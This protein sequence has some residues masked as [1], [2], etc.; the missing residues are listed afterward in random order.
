MLTN[1]NFVVLLGP[2]SEAN[3]IGPAINVATLK[4]DREAMYTATIFVE[5][6]A[7]R[8][9]LQGSLVKNPQPTDW[10]NIKI[11]ETRYIEYPLTPGQPRGDDIGDTAIDKFNF[12]GNYL[13]IRAVVDKTQT[14]NPSGRVVQ[15]LLSDEYTAELHNDYDDDL[16]PIDP[17]QPIPAGALTA[18][19]A[20]V[21]ID[22]LGKVLSLSSG[23]P[24]LVSSQT[25]IRDQYAELALLQP[26]K[27]DAAFITGELDPARGYYVY[28]G[29]SWHGLTDN[30]FAIKRDVV[31]GTYVNATVQVDAYG[32]V[33]QA[34]SGAIGVTSGVRTASFTALDTEVNVGDVYPLG[35]HINKITVKANQSF[36]PA[37]LVS[38]TDSVQELISPDEL[39]L[40]EDGLTTV[41]SVD[42]TYNTSNFFKVLLNNNG[43]AQGSGEVTIYFTV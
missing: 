5:E 14:A 9:Y 2:T 6:F 31:P 7:G 16:E 18:Q 24:T 29:T 22:R 21:T 38:I 23:D 11:G 32:R 40:T 4:R 8:V 20:T 41:F 39:D 17:T 10:F 12:A 15:V 34:Q 13:R 30:D 37:C 25:Y 1:N 19:F 26:Q 28:T 33:V 3:K 36:D 42:T 43:T 27:G 35:A